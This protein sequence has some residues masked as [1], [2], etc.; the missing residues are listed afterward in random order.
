MSLANRISI[1]RI[2]LAPFLLASLLY[3]HPDR[4]WLRYV[5]LGLFLIGVVSDALDG[6]IARSRREQSQL[7]AILDPIADKL[8]ILGAL[9]SLSTI[10]NL[11]PVLRIPAWF[12]LIVLSRDAI[13]IVGTMVIFGLTGTIAIR[14]TRTGKWAIAAQMLVVPVVLLMW[15]VK[16]ACLIIAAALTVCSGIGYIRMG[17]QLLDPQHPKSSA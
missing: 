6:F 11:P 15:P 7:G 10:K 5:S 2:L 14:P 13:L 17:I 16:M 8:L 9:I 12:N 3:Y 1:F 4:D